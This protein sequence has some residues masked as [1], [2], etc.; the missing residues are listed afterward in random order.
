MSKLSPIEAPQVRVDIPTPCVGIKDDPGNDVS[1]YSRVVIPCRTQLC[2]SKKECLVLIM[3][4]SETIF[5]SLSLSPIYY[6]KRLRS[7]LSVYHVLIKNLKKL[8][9]TRDK[10]RKYELW[11]LM[12]QRTR[13]KITLANKA[14][15]P[16]SGCKFIP[17]RFHQGTQYGS[18]AVS[19]LTGKSQCEYVDDRR[20]SSPAISYPQFPHSP[21]F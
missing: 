9:K 14:I 19:A 7:L 18:I 6:S 16:L 12:Y 20:T 5:M 4:G 15:P 3:I 11:F 1:I 2:G 13:E 17:P 8:G 10:F 21:L